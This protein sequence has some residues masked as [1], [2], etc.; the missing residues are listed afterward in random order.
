MYITSPP[1]ASAPSYDLDSGIDVVFQLSNYIVGESIRIHSG[2]KVDNTPDRS[3]NP[4][5]GSGEARFIC[6]EIGFHG[7]FAAVTTRVDNQQLEYISQ[8]SQWAAQVYMTSE[9]SDKQQTD[10]LAFTEFRGG[11]NSAI[12]SNAVVDA[13]GTRDI[14]RHKSFAIKPLCVLT[15][16]P[17][18]DAQTKY[19]TLTLRLNSNKS[20]I[21]KQ[22][23]GDD[24]KIT[25]DNLYITYETIS[26]KMASK[27]MEQMKE[28][29]YPIVSTQLL[30]IKSNQEFLSL[31]LPAM[32]RTVGWI[33]SVVPIYDSTYGA[34]NQFRT[35]AIPNLSRL[36]FTLNGRDINQS[37]PMTSGGP[38]NDFQLELYK[39]QRVLQLGGLLNKPSGFGSADR[40]FY[41]KLDGIYADAFDPAGIEF[42]NS[43]TLGF[44]I[45]S[46]VESVTA[47]KQFTMY[48]TLISR[49]KL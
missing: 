46:N 29:T 36:R 17:I 11:H 9:S 22:N 41:Y 37:F 16:M 10:S 19:I 42:N 48:L 6:P 35:V 47:A 25:L 20:F 12:G 34:Y 18:I 1:L 26:E 32:G 39:A 27:M 40:E 23:A 38:G 43:S 44:E 28:L 21:V 45:N 33:A 13:D 14:C 31:N 7:A 30:S 24:L 4:E 5:F 3:Q 8:Y 49:A 15:S 2:Y